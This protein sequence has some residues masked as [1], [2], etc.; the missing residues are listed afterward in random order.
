VDQPD[1]FSSLEPDRG[2]GPGR[3]EGGEPHPM[4]RLVAATDGS[5]LRNPGPGGWC[6]YVN[7]DCWGA[8]GEPDT[9]NNRM[10]LLAVAALLESLPAGRPVHIMAD[11][12]YVI[13]ALT[14][15]RHGWKKRGWKTASGEPVK[16]RDLMERLD[17]LVIERMPTFEWVRGHDGHAA[18]EAADERA[19]AAAEAA[20]SGVA[21]IGG[22][23]L[24]P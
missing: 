15:W 4:A 24:V 8:G 22:P 21:C 7:D 9:T 3:V 17:A 20:K 14:K 12:S 11:S 2:P 16:N 13:D 18:N 10:E 1:L 23:G 19:R 5:C 6:W